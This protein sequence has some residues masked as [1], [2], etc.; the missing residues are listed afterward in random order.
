MFIGVAISISLRVSARHYFVFQAMPDSTFNAEDIFFEAIQLP[1]TDRTAFIQKACGDDHG[2]RAELEALLVSHRRNEED[3][4]IL[5]RPVDDSELTDFADIAESEGDTIGRYRLLE[6]IGEGGMG[7][8]YMAEQIEGVRRRVALK[9]IKLGMD[10]RQIIARFEAERQAMA[11][12]DHPCITRV[13]DAGATSTGRPYF[14]MELVRGNS[15]TKYVAGNSLSLRQRLEL[16][17]EVCR[18]VH[19]AHQKGVIH[20][21]LKPSNILVTQFD[22]IPVPK[23]IDF[24]IA[25]AIGQQRL[26]EKTLFTRYASMVGTPQYM[27]PEQAEMTGLDIDTR[28]DIYSL[29]VILYEL[30]TGSTPLEASM[31]RP[32]NLLALYETLRDANIE[33]PSSRLTRL[34]KLASTVSETSSQSSA[35]IH[36][37][38]LKG[39]LDW[40]VMKAL[41]RDRKMRYESA[42]DLAADVVCYLAGDP[43]DAAPPSRIYLLKT[44]LRKYRRVAAGIVAFVTLLLVAVVACSWLAFSNYRTSLSLA[45]SNGRLESSNQ[46]L[47][48]T[49]EQ[50][51]LAEMRIRQSAEKDKYASAISMAMLQFGGKFSR[52][53]ERVFSANHASEAQIQSVKSDMEG[54]AESETETANFQSFIFGGPK[55]NHEKLLELQH[56]ELLMEAIQPLR[57]YFDEQATVSEQLQSAMPQTRNREIV[58]VSGQSFPL[59]TSKLLSNRAP[60]ELN[61]DKAIER[62]KHQFYRILAQEYRRVFGESDP[63][64]AEALNL[65][66]ACLLDEERFDEAES[67]LRESIAIADADD[68]KTAKALLEIIAVQ[69]REK[70]RNDNRSEN[71]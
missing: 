23:V 43:V 13:L 14:V 66:A 40:I 18:A 26:T 11:L 16:F 62:T 30:I 69:Q 2:L 52:E 5:G 29:G 34:N 37:E 65:L 8:V 50:L 9:I 31:L 53:L 15:I 33:T 59:S 4:F 10:T 48:D 61:T 28:T 1:V 24:G 36:P 22:G 70:S 60:I 19:H 12:F 56:A 63:H 46:K 47:K 55:P 7:R 21:D 49:V 67:R 17:I 27:S 45:E 51:Q 20:R 41:A 38:R 35:T 68:R 42:N 32:L 25:K 6:L 64:I 57:D 58:I 54:R 39:D 71:E 44:V 3:D